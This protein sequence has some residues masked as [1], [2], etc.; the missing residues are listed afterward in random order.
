MTEETVKRLFFST[1]MALAFSWAAYF[2]FDRECGSESNPGNKQRYLPMLPNYLLPL[3]FVVLW[4]AG[5]LFQG[6]G[7]T[8]KLTLSLCFSIFLQIS[9]YYLIL[10]PLLPLLRRRISA[11]SCAMLWLV[12][13]YLYFIHYD[14]MAPQSPAFVI[15][16]PGN[17]AFILLGVWFAGFIGVLVWKTVGHL[18][19]RRMIE[20]NA[21]PHPDPEIRAMLKTAL[22]E[23][24]YPNIHIPL[25]VSP[26]VST[27]L[28]LGLFRRSIAVILP[29]KE[30]TREEL[31]L[32]F[33][34]ETVHICREDSWSKFF[35][36]FCT[37][38]CWFNPLM[39]KAMSRSAEDLEL[40][41]DET[42]LLGADDHTRK[43]YARLILNAAGDQRGFSTCLSASAEALR[44]RLKQI[45]RLGVRKSG[46]TV[47][48][49]SFFLLAVSGGYI[50]LAYNGQSGADVIY[51]S[52]DPSQYTLE[53]LFP[54]DHD[55]DAVYQVKDLDA[56]H[57]YL[58]GLTLYEMTGTYT[59]SD[60]E[61]TMILDL[62]N[63]SGTL[64]L[65]L[66]DNGIQIWHKNRLD[67]P[68]TY[69]HVPEGIDWDCL[70]ALVMER[71]TLEIWLTKPEAPKGYTVR[72][73]ITEFSRI[74]GEERQVLLH[75]LDPATGLSN[76]H[77]AEASL[78]FSHIPVG[79]VTVLVENWDRSDGYTVI[80]DSIEEFP[81][82]MLPGYSAHYTV[83]ARFQDTTGILF[84]AEYRFHLNETAQ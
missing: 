46:A 84:E 9:L 33:R 3:F 52:G 19:F 22:A 1:L 25:M 76:Y 42:V 58:S 73:F 44:Y 77:A 69:Y 27:P 43:Q 71:P 40:S 4:I 60:R 63:R 39:W 21:V 75:Q 62:G 11:R 37:A 55:G 68:I 79:P 30:Y 64:R 74:E 82:L 6:F 56:L 83:T 17:L 65:Y 36:V 16:S 31:G 59:F 80:L 41:C 24:R 78:V 14:F 7:W 47:V 28:T 29:Q 57:E 72:A 70:D 18:R 34:H 66:S 49:L 81:D 23:A 2:R 13:N 54:G 8:Q 5:L 10:I 35:L 26:D 15:V 67:A 45:T 53:Y 51:Q 61:Q 38:L 12:P 32:I 50:A 20:E 48:G